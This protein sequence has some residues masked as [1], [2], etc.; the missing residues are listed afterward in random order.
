[1]GVKH[2]PEVHVRVQPARRLWCVFEL[3]AFLQSHRAE[4]D[5]GSLL[6]KPIV[7]APATFANIMMSSLLVGIWEFWNWKCW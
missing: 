7:L 4:T 2:Q 1:M 5:G 3:A 6:I